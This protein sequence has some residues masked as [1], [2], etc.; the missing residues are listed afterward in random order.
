MFGTTELSVNQRILPRWRR[1]NVDLLRR[2]LVVGYV[3]AA[4]TSFIAVS[5][6]GSD[7][8]NLGLLV[9]A[10]V[11]TGVA[12]MLALGRRLPGEVI[13]LVAFSGAI[14][15][16]GLATVFA[17][18]LGP[19]PL[20]YL[21]P[22]LTC[23]YFGTR[24]DARVASVLMCVS[25]AVAL[26]FAND[27]QVPMITYI[28]VVSIFVIVLLAVQRQAEHTDEL[29]Q[30]LAHAAA[31][32]S[33]TGLLDRRAF[34]QAFEREVERARTSG[35][36]LSLVF[37]DLDH[38]KAVN[39]GYGHAAGD[40]ALCAFARILEH[41]CSV[42]DLFARMGGEEFASV[43]FDADGEVAKQ[44]A[45]QTAMALARWSEQ[46]PPQLTTSVGIAVL[47][48]ETATPSQMLIAADRALYAA[49]AAGRNR[50][51]AS[52]QTTARVLVAA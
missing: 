38:F 14:L 2:L 22:A 26:R 35:L 8:G 50:V 12:V 27:V 32:D 20:Y 23:G 6:P 10:V 15:F 42:A 3:A 40:E 36:D 49:K 37:F 5:L 19:T 30:E 47:S 17:R 33:L 4:L 18:P 31:T 52:G 51:L 11:E 9:L 43:L 48:D 29:V 46:H 34:S 41:E 24:R 1:E 28:S 16:V 7:H 44:F 25:F 39:D 21:W 13:K 45:E